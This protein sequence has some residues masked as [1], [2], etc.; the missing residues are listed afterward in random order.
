MT[1]LNVIWAILLLGVIIFCHEAGHYTVGRLCGIGVEEFSVGFGPALLSRERK[2]IRYSLRAIPLGGYVRFTG[3][4]ETSARANAFNNHPVWKRFLTVA[5]GALMN[6]VLAFA[7][8]LLL[9]SLYSY[10]QVPAF[11][12]VLP[13]APAA[14]VGLRAGD[15]VLAV[16]GEEITWDQA[17]FDRM[18]DLF[19][20]RQDAT[21]FELTVRRGEETLT[22]S[23]GK[24]PAEDGRWLLGVTLGETEYLAP[25]FALRESGVAFARMSTMMLDVLRD[26]FFKGEG[27]DQL[28]GPVGVIGEVSKQIRQGFDMVLNMLAVISMNL[29]IINLL[30]LPALD[31]GRLVF[32]IVEAIRRKPVP[33][34]KEGMVHLAGMFVLLALM[35]VLTYGDIMRLIHG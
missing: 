7:A 15:R 24:A 26:L 14:E 6:F 32:L 1:V 21:P 16:D 22:V 35:V 30:P 2:G 4:D 33:P 31:G 13:G 29:G 5:A 34:E 28:S 8:I 19:D 9:V 11:S 18:Y 23:V 20:A 12:E 17:G 27:A 10:Q 3:E 25:H